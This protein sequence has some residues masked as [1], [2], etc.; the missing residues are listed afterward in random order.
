MSRGMRET[1]ESIAIALALAFLFKTF[2]AEAFVIPTGSMAPTLMGRHKDVNCPK[3]GYRY[4]A[5]GSDEADRNGVELRDPSLQ[6]IACTCPICRF[7]MSV[8]P[9]DPDNSGRNAHPSYTGDRIWV[10]K[11]PYHFAEPRRFDVV[12]FRFPE[13]AETY[14]IKRLIGLPN[15]TVKL[16]H[17]DVY[18]KGPQD[19]DFSIVR[20]PTEKLL[21][22]AQ[23]VHDNDY[24]SAEL[25]EHG[26]PA[27]WQEWGL[28]GPSQWKMSPDTRSYSTDG[29]H[30]GDAW[31]RYEHTV[32]SELNWKAQRWPPAYDPAPE[33]ITDF[34]A[35]N[36]DMLRRQYDALPEALGLHWVGDLILD[37]QVDV[38]SAQ[39]SL[40]FDL[41]KG[42]L[43]F[44]CTIDVATGRAQLS[45]EGQ[46][47]F[48]PAAETAIRDPGQ[49]SV[50]F[51]NV[52]R[53]LRLWI[54]GELVA[55]DKPTTY[56]DLGNDRPRSDD[57]DPGDL[58]PLGIGSRGAKLTVN[59]LRVLRDIYYI[60]DSAG[61]PPISDYG[62]SASVPI[63]NRRQLANFLSSPRHWESGRG[64]SEFDARHSEVFPLA[65]DQFFVLG[66]NSPHSL[67]ARLW[68]S[69]HYVERDLLVG[70]ALFVYWPHPLRLF[71]PFTDASISIIPNFPGMG[72]IR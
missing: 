57:T 30:A 23:V 26:W 8:D 20:K 27:R 55:F 62:T 33:L 49:H 11:V 10:S 38:Q 65:D 69:Q 19:A 2:E 15:E 51:A 6:V 37:C 14:Y 12:V 31:I 5:N 59:H 16:F 4:S 42:G 61:G 44:G 53:E 28:S 7:P 43:H 67:D 41:V 25:L 58:A 35:F 54:D 72:L 9:Q 32:P 3:C 21:A 50:M 22:M 63:L 13:E 18:I 29:T 60:A 36:T 47:D 71:I 66:D 46:K 39:G 40:L 48:H 56:D 70:K 24:V 45:I 68:T 64:G 1:I 17:G 34:Y 52:D